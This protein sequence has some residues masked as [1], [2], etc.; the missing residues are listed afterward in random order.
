LELLLHKAKNISTIEDAKVLLK[1]YFTFESNIVSMA[2]ELCISA[3]ETQFRKSGEPY[4]IHPIIVAT[5]A[6]SISEDETIVASALLH[7]V[8][9]DTKYKSSDIRKKFGR[10]VAFVVDGL[11]KISS[12][13]AEQLA[14]SSENQYLKSTALTFEKMIRGAIKDPRIL[15]VKLSDRLHNLTTLEA[16]RADKR[17]RIATES[18]EVYAPIAH[19]LGINILKSYIEDLSFSYINPEGYA[20]VKGYLQRESMKIE[21]R[22]HDVID[23]I[24]MQMKIFG[25][26]ENDF[27]IESRV[28]HLYSIYQKMQTKGV[29]I[30]DILDIIGIRVLVKR[31]IDCYT[32]LGLIHTNYR[33]MMNRFKDYITL[34]KDNGYQTIQT[35]IFD[36]NGSAC[37]VQIRTYEMN[38]IADRGVASHL[39]YKHPHRGN[40]AELADFFA[41]DMSAEDSYSLAKGEL[42]IDEITIQSPKGDTFSFPKGSIALDFAY[43]IH[44]DIGNQAISAFVNKKEVNLSYVLRDMDV[45]DIR[46]DKNALL[47]YSMK[48]LLKTPKAQSLLEK[49]Y[50][51]NL[52]EIGK[53]STIN[54]F[55]TLFD[56]HELE[57]REFFKNSKFKDNFYKALINPLIYNEIVE[58]IIDHPF[59]IGDD[60][61]RPLEI[62]KDGFI[63]KTNKEV[64]SVEFD[65]CCH[66][67]NGNR[68]VAF[69][70]GGH[71]VVHH[72]LCKDAY[73]LISDGE[74][75]IYCNWE[76]S[77]NLYQ[78]TVALKNTKGALADL[79]TKLVSMDINVSNMPCGEINAQKAEYFRFD[80][81]SEEPTSKA[82]RDKLSKKIKLIDIVSLNDAYNK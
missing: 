75:M 41:S 79:L 24:Q 32:V 37:E 36:E 60:F 55:A 22:L 18:M 74:E 73:K 44:T 82:L 63:L 11:T 54:I 57:V 8:V 40:I 52:R 56:L 43:E 27:T 66:P 29:D 51:S 1:E 31:D 10:D 49:A 69:Y 4:A 14:S 80:I 38:E 64:Q 19:R 26:E 33:P 50:K 7:D 58:E 17:L 16:L 65:Y 2:L 35:T 46:T 70:N 76:K 68:I 21:K 53:L 9:E 67:K 23:T 28:K 3:H 42:F 59:L 12:I 81:E 62:H 20:Y 13:R 34:P 6:S 15:I 25:F 77:L 30:N 71:V 72:R 61:K 48:E 5:I 47:K 45:V 78:I 39:S